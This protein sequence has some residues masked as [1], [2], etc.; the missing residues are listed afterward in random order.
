MKKLIQKSLRIFLYV[1]VAIAIL[2]L[3]SISV[4]YVNKDEIWIST[5]E[6][7]CKILKS[8]VEIESVGLSIPL[9]FPNLALKVKNLSI[10]DSLSGSQV[11]QINTFDADIDLWSV[12]MFKPKINAVTVEDASLDLMSDSL[13]NLNFSI[14]SIVDTSKTKAIPKP[15]SLHFDMPI[16][17]IILKNVAIHLINVS[18]HK[19]IGL[20]AINTEITISQSK[21]ETNI[22]VNGP[23][24][25]NG[26]GFDTRLGYF[27]KDKTVDA[28]ISAKIPVNENKL[29]FL[30]SYVVIDE[31]SYNVSGYFKPD[32]YPD[33]AIIIQTDNAVVTKVLPCLSQNVALKIADYQVTNTVHAVI[34][35]AGPLL[36]NQ[37]PSIDLRFWSEGNIFKFKDWPITI[38]GINFEG[39]VCNHMNPDINRGDPNTSFEIRS[40][41][42]KIGPGDLAANIKIFDLINPTIDVNADVNVNLAN[43]ASSFHDFPFEQAK[44]N[45]KLNINYNGQFPAGK[46]LSLLSEWQYRGYILFDEIAFKAGGIYYENINGKMKF[47]NDT[48]TL[49]KD[50]TFNIAGN[51]VL[52]SGNI[53]KPIQHFIMPETLLQAYIKLQSKYFDINK[54][55]VKSTGKPVATKSRS[56]SQKSFAT[57]KKVLKNMRFVIALDFK[58]A[59]F[60]KLKVQNLKGELCRFDENMELKNIHLGLSGGK[61]Q[62]NMKA[63]NL[64]TDKQQGTASI[65]IRNI[66]VR[67]LFYGM[68]NFD[69]KAI[70]SQNLEGKFDADIIFATRF[71]DGYQIK[72]SSM[73][74]KLDFSL[75]N[76]HLKNF[77]PLQN[78]SKFIFK[79]RDFTN[80]SFDELSQ[81]ATLKGI[82][83]DISEMKI[84]SNVITLYVNGSYSFDN[85][86]DLKIRVPWFNLRSNDKYLEALQKD[87]EHAKAIHIRAY[88]KAGKISFGLGK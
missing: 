79:N 5:K 70:T 21:G 77:E 23:V 13:G 83:L 28:H 12:I 69:Q 87:P 57:V 75:R 15:I 86:V 60:R 61:M 16:Q 11:F 40:V 35:I 39:I 45:A 31:E 22:E 73:T 72:P 59:L 58:E 80:I 36:P 84:Q 55:M 14:L 56:S 1:L 4:L 81:H 3:I 47:R 71:A 38:S 68:D 19:N 18:E 20:K 44:G 2:L 54:L 88:T 37:D 8:N 27:L 30:P 32:I 17:K 78:I 65:R 67:K 76:G 49:P 48:V 82:K 7:L 6:N 46:E 42:G 9:H 26:L 63:N 41:T 51:T 74:G 85:N 52:A 62:V 66:D 53:Y 25:F 10:T 29:Y 64:D 33:I 24:Y 50:F 34:T 43:L